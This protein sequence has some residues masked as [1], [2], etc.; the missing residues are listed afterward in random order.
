MF[1]SCIWALNSVL[2]YTFYKSPYTK[3]KY[4]VLFALVFR[5]LPISSSFTTTAEMHRVCK[6]NG[7]FFKKKSS[8]F[9]QGNCKFVICIDN[10]WSWG[11]IIHFFDIR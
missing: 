2:C 7:H 1:N 6:K 3:I 8:A 10:S 11:P 5:E 4:L 9:M